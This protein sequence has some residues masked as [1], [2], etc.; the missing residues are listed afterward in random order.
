MRNFS[1]KA[2]FDDFLIDYLGKFKAVYKSALARESG[3]WGVGGLIDEK[4]RGLK[5]S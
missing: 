1:K 4:R 3:P 5:I 2:D